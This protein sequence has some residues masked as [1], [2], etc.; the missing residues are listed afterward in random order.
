LKLKPA[1]YDLKVQDANGCEDSLSVT[2]IEPPK[3]TIALPAI[4]K[5]T[6]GDD[7]QFN[8]VIDPDTMKLVEIKWTPADSLSCSNCLNPLI[9]RPF[10]GGLFDLYVKNDKGCDARA[11]TRLN[12]DRNIPVYAPTAF[13][14]NG[15]KI[16]DYF[17]LFG[18]IKNVIKIN[19]LRIFDRWGTLIFEA[20]DLNPSVESQ[21]WDGTFRGEPLN[22]AVFVWNAQIRRV[23]GEEENLKGDVLLEK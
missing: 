12:V 11:S 3:L 6:I 23:D 15:D 2:I 22:P 19:H 4:H 13:S 14:P 18:N 10:R 5:I 20:F 21:G 8:P 7:V 1:T 9:T 17:T 16:N